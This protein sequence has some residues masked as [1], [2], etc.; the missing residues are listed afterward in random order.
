MYQ[1]NNVQYLWNSVNTRFA[2]CGNVFEVSS[3]GQ[4]K[5][6]IGELVIAS[7]AAYRCVDS[8][9]PNAEDCDIR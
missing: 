4:A 1:D 5:R 9:H 6:W 3:I 2:L 7:R 8:L